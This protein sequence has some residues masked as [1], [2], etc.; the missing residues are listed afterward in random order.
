MKPSSCFAIVA[1]AHS[2][3]D[4]KPQPG[5]TTSEVP[6]TTTLRGDKA[7]VAKLAN[8]LP[9]APSTKLLAIFTKGNDA[10]WTALPGVVPKRAE[11]H[12]FVDDLGALG[13]PARHERAGFPSEKPPKT[14]RSNRIAATVEGPR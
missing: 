12:I 11:A 8:S 5:T 3:A 13:E 7:E 2:A 14:M 9:P 10:A 1:V 4:P 6:A